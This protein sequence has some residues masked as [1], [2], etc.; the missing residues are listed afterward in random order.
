MA[1]VIREPAV[2][3]PVRNATEARAAEEYFLAVEATDHG[4]HLVTTD[5]IE[6]PMLMPVPDLTAALEASLAVRGER[7]Q[8]EAS[9]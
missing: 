6:E 9:A 1:D 8:S 4:E 7:A 3:L 2:M 5:V